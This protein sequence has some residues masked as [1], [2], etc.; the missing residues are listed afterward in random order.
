MTTRPPQTDQ[1]LECLLPEGSRIKLI[2]LGGIGSIVLEYLALYLA[3]LNRDLELSLVDGDAFEPRNLQRMHFA[4]LGNKAEVKVAELLGRLP[5]SE[6]TL[7]AVP[8]Y[9]RPET[10]ERIILPGDR[11]LLCVD[12]HPTRRL[13]GEYCRQLPD[14][15][16]F[17][18]GNDGIDPQQGQRG[19][20]ANV[21]IA[22]RASGRDLSAPLTRYHPEIARAAGEL[23]GGPDCQ[24]LAASVPQILST[25]LAAA[26]AL[27]NAFF[28]YCC[29]RL[30]Y[31]E[32]QLDILEARMVPQFELD[33]PPQP[34]ASRACR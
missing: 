19:T 27:L 25:N 8:E 7:L 22:L 32:V 13:I 2:G 33:E 11:V 30:A 18:A 6:L 28:A 1:E 5:D 34:G 4:S 24:Q 17:S 20:Y 21:Q 15:A 14:C 23:P 12:N 31:Q 3:G 10:I 16:L 26:S 9:V 29:G